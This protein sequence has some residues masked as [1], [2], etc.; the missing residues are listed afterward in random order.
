MSGTHRDLFFRS[1]SRSIAFKNHL[2]GL[3]P[4]E[5][6]HSD[7]KTAVVHAQND[8]SCL[9]PIETCHSGPK[10]AVWHAKTTDEG[11]DT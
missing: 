7:V 1:K 8:R 2:R 5:T 3:G 9:G 10:C 6:S 4:I 11:W